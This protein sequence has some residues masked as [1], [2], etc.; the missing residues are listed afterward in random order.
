[1]FEY[2]RVLLSVAWKVLINTPKV[3]KYARHPEK[4]PIEERFAVVKS[5][6]SK[7]INAFHVDFYTEGL[8][9]FLSYKGKRLIVMNHLSFLDALAFISKCEKPITFVAKKESEKYFLVG[10]YIK[11]IS[12]L[13]LDRENLMNQ[14]RSLNEAIKLAKDPNGPDVVIFPEGT[15]N[16]VAGSRCLEFKAGTFKIAMKSNVAIFPVSAYGAFR[17]LDTKIHMK[18][19]PIFVKCFKPILPDE[20]LNSNSFEIADRAQKAI[21]Q[22]ILESKKADLEIV[23]SMKLSKKMR[24]RV[25]EPDKVE[26]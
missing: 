21:D 18:R 17:P 22:G 14:V 16:K 3:R 23:S 15:R 13:F 12:G 19:Y 8:D 24:L 10:T 25:E 6:L 4:Y 11:A 1:M 26:F 7:I 2:I 9:E 20:Y 5:V